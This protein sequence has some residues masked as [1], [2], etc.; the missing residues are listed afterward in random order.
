MERHRVSVKADFVMGCGDSE[1]TVW[2]LNPLKLG[3]HFENKHLEVIGY[4]EEPCR[5]DFYKIFER[6]KRLKALEQYHEKISK[7]IMGGKKVIS[8]DLEE[9]ELAFKA[10]NDEK[11]LWSSKSG[12]ELVVSEHV[13]PWEL[14]EELVGWGVHPV[15]ARYAAQNYLDEL[16]DNRNSVKYRLVRL[17]KRVSRIFK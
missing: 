1:K 11:L 6:L 7:K 5:A 9:G 16:V 13:T 14:E 2:K 4:E 15:Q 10:C 3:K 8:E 12:L 17:G